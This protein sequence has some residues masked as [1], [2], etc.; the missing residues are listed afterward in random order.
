M[1]M[2][3]VFGAFSLISY[4]YSISYHYRQDKPWGTHSADHYAKDFRCINS[5]SPPPNLKSSAL[6][7]IL[8]MKKLRPS[9]D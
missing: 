1:I 9:R 8:Q 3:A 4:Q 7:P 6:N 5:L 2:I